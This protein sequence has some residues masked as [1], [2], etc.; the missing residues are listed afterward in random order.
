MTPRRARPR[1]AGAA[2]AGPSPL[3]A[4]AR[5]FRRP[6]AVRGRTGRDVRARVV[7]VL[8]V[9]A[10]ALRAARHP[11][12]P[13]SISTRSSISATTAAGRS[14]RCSRSAPARRRFRRS[15]SA[16]DDR[17]LHRAVRCVR[18]RRRAQAARAHRRRR[19]RCRS[20]IRMPS[21]R[22]GCNRASAQTENADEHSRRVPVV[23]LASSDT[24]QH[25]RG[26]RRRVPR[27]GLLSGDRSRH[28]RVAV[29]RN[30]P[31]RCVRSS[32]SR[33][34]P[35]AQCRAPAREPVGFL[36][37]G[38]H[39]EHARLE[40]DLRLRRASCG[41]VGA[42][43][44]ADLPG[45]QGHA[46]RLLPRLRSRG[47]AAAPD[48]LRE[49]RHAGARARSCISRAAIELRAAELLPRVPGAGTPG[50]RGDADARPPRREPSHRCRRADGA[51][52]GS[53]ARSRSVPPT[54]AGGRSSR[55]PRALVVNIGD[56]V[57]V[58][59]NDRY[60]APLHRVTRQRRGRSASARRSSSVRRTSRLRAAA[61]TVDA[62]HPPRYRAINWGEFYAMRRRRLRRPRRRNSDHA[63][64]RGGAMTMA[65]I[66]TTDANCATGDVRAMYERQQKSWGYVPNY[67]KLFSHRPQVLTAWA[68]M[69]AVIR[70]SGRR[71]HVRTRDVRRSVRARQ[72]VVFAGARQETDRPLPVARRSGAPLHPDEKPRRR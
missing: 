58:W 50:R 12:S 23:D 30:I 32:R 34:T 68:D 29:R 16:V 52:A 42:A 44:A 7:R 38:A 26:D 37:P 72:F 47:D 54:A 5:A 63:V 28:R 17:R 65:F 19:A 45:L 18:Q 43:V 35:S 57:Q 3:D 22:S 66:E 46:D 70:R 20:S 11:V 8:L 60:Q 49:S 33:V 55:S 53:A 10:Q 24:A 64:S 1:R 13:A 71:A 62:Q 4:E 61:P 67:A 6:T 21:C 9:G 39:E 15:S 31:A 59:S 2:P 40:G 48:R 27:L 25:A 56:I 69:I 14:A 51:A 41:D 36:R